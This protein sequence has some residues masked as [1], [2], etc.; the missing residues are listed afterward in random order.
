LLVLDDR[1]ASLS[2]PSPE[3]SQTSHFKRNVRLPGRHKVLVNAEVQLQCR[4]GEPDSASAGQIGG[5]RNLLKPDQRTVERQGNVFS[6][7]RYGD[8]NMVE[9]D[10]TDI[11]RLSDRFI[12]HYRLL[13]KP[14]ILSSGRRTP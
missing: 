13:A 12:T 7:G 3:P 4:R 5:L 9:P 14:G 10:S 8:L 11:T 6:A 1:N 2:K